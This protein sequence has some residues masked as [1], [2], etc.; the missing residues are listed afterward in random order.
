LTPKES[1]GEVH[2]AELAESR[3]LATFYKRMAE[4][5]R[6]KYQKIEQDYALLQHTSDYE[7]EKAK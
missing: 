4:E 5:Y 6:G 2:Y 1:L 7:L 3:E